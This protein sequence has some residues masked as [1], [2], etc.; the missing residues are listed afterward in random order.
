MEKMEPRPRFQVQLV[1]RRTLAKGAEAGQILLAVQEDPAV[2]VEQETMGQQAVADQATARVRLQ[3]QELLEACTLARL[4]LTVLQQRLLLPQALLIAAEA[5]E[6][7][8]QT[9]TTQ[10]LALQKMEEEAVVEQAAVVVGQT[11][12]LK[13]AT[14]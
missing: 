11:T 7:L 3:P 6:A 2:L 10:A 12:D 9:P 1:I 5:A 13:Q 14:L 8:V 4:E